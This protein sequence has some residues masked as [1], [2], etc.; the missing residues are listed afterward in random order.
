MEV[1]HII[2]GKAN[3]DRLNGVNKV[4]FNM[5]TEQKRAGKNVQVWGIT[6]NPVHDYPV[7]DFKTLLFR[8]EILPFNINSNLKKAI[9]QNKEAVFHLHGG[10]IPVFSSIA[11]FFFRNHIRY[12]ITPHGAYNTVAMKRSSLV[13]KIYFHFFEKSLIRN[14]LKVH[15]IGKSEVDGLKSIFPDAHSFLLP[16][17]FEWTGK[18]VKTTKSETFTIG[19]LG[20]LDTHTKGL[21]LLLSA[22]MHFRKKHTDSR[23]WIIG[24]GEGRVYIENFIKENK[25]ENVMLWGKKFGQEKDEL[26]NMMHVF[27]HPSRNE[28]LPTAVLEAAALGIPAIVSEATNVAWYVRR[29]NAGI[30]IADENINEFVQALETLW[31]AYQHGRQHQFQVGARIMLSDVFA[32]PALVEK[33]EEL[34][35]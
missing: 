28:G 20:R 13:K 2:L 9:L 19:F 27:A 12:V 34:Y 21:D 8:A 23:L 31:N 35:K 7:R 4:V 22:F 29:Y 1:I 6:P 26:V 25:I 15:S 14:A 33:Y 17:G 24:E 5:A 3:P 30:A 32:W 16:Y 18:P 10:W 11:G